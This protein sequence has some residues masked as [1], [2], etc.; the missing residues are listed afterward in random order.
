[1]GSSLYNCH[2]NNTKGNVSTIQI[3]ISKHTDYHIHIIPLSQ[4]KQHL[5]EIHFDHPQVIRGYSGRSY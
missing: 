1:M 3:I 4:I 5:A 2:I